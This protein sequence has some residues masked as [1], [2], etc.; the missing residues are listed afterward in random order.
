MAPVGIAAMHAVHSAGQGL[1]QRQRQ[2]QISPRK[3]YD[4]RRA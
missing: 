2:V 1:G 3:K 4:P